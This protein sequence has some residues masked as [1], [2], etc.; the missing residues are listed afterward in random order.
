MTGVW[1]V[2]DPDNNTTYETPSR[3]EAEDALQ[4]GGDIRW[5]ERA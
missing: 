4:N 2:T 1:V 5:E 3:T